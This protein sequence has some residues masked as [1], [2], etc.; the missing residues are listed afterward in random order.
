ML[1]LVKVA[2]G[3]VLIFAYC[4]WRYVVIPP[5]V[6]WAV[7]PETWAHAAVVYGFVFW[8]VVKSWA[9]ESHS[10]RHITE[11]DDD[12]RRSQPIESGPLFPRLLFDRNRSDGRFAASR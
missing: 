11:G 12:S 3:A 5:L 6:T 4:F 8:L 7:G 10:I 2:A 1:E 9:S